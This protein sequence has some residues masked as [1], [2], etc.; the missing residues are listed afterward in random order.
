MNGYQVARDSM[1]AA[2]QQLYR[3]EQLLIQLGK[4]EGRG[5]LAPAERD[6]ILADLEE[7]F[8]V[9]EAQHRQLADGIAELRRQGKTDGP[10]SDKL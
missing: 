5:R 1:K 10:P 6:K 4:A 7:G 2:R 3:C 9:L 8:R